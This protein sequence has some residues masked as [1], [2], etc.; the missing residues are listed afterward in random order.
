MESNSAS[1]PVI[2]K[3]CQML[4][5]FSP[6]SFALMVFVIGVISVCSCRVKVK[7]ILIVALRHED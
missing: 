6:V 2:C 1:L 4:S 7:R 5:F 3:P